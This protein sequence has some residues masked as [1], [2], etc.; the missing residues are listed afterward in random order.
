MVKWSP[1][2]PTAAGQD[3]PHIAMP[4]EPPT[5]RTAGRSSHPASPIS[6]DKTTLR[7]GAKHPMPV[8]NPEALPS[9]WAPLEAGCP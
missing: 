6:L 8:T 2:E 1:M 9:V 4:T 3:V 5:A 7:R